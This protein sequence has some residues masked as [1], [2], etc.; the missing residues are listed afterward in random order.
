MDGQGC[1]AE[2]LGSVVWP[3]PASTAILDPVNPLASPWAML[4]LRVARRGRCQERP[5]GKVTSQSAQTSGN[6]LR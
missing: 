6:S 4:M 1:K 5:E 3:A 2:N